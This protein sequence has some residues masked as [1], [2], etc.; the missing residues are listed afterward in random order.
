MMAHEPA[1]VGDGLLMRPK[2]VHAL[3]GTRPF[4]G[5]VN[6]L[7]AWDCYTMGY[8]ERSRARFADPE[9]LP[10][11]YDSGGNAT[12]VVLVE[13]KV[14][15]LWDFT[16]SERR[17]DIR[18]GLFEEPTPRIS[19]TIEAEAGLVA[20]YFNA[21]ETTIRRVKIRSPISKGG[22]HLKPLAP[23]KR[24]KPAEKPPARPKKALTGRKSAAAKNR[25]R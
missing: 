1:D 19:A 21:R 20:A 16:L 11:L 25:A 7:P 12:S 8:A 6:L 5:R 18:V 3:D 15:G 9:V 14:G 23:E 4:A 13:G 24:T 2:D 22:S 17:I 10:Y